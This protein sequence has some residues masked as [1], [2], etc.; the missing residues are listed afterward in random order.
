METRDADTSRE[1]EKQKRKG[2]HEETVRTTG[3]AC[4]LEELGSRDAAAQKTVGLRDRK[5]RS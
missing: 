3:R 2:P 1:R 5:E 4:E